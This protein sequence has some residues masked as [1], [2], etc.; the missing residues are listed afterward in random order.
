MNMNLDPRKKYLFAF[1][2]PDDDVGI[3][4]TMR[5]LVRRVAEVHCVWATS[6]DFFGQGE[7]R[8]AETYEAADVL[9]MPKS[10]VHLLK[11]PD[12]SLVSKLNEAADAMAELLRVIRP[13]VILADAYEGGHPDHDSVNFM[14]VEG[15]IRAG[16]TPEL[17]EFPLYNGSGSPL[18]LGWR[19]NSFPPGGPTVLHTVLDEDAIQCKYRMMRAHSSQWM[20]MV[21]ARMA[22]SRSRLCTIGEPYRPFSKDRD[23]TLPPH[24]GRL[25]YERWFNFFMGI[26]FNDFRKAVISARDQHNR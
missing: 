6:G 14:V 2:H 13:D 7:T 22:C 1:A 11:F 24:G 18:Q 8:E 12:L 20:F 25:G 21:P 10:N 9:A 26:R 4:G 23:Y 17:F 16:L 19:L 5:L 15:S 3:A